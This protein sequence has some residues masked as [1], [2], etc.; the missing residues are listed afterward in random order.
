MINETETTEYLELLNDST[1]KDIE[2]LSIDSIKRDNPTIKELQF[3]IDL[4]IKRN[5]HIVANEARAY[6]EANFN[7][8]KIYGACNLDV[9]Y[10]HIDLLDVDVVAG[11]AAPILNNLGTYYKTKNGHKIKFNLSIQVGRDWDKVVLDLTVK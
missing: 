5:D 7:I 6:V 2:G 11:D 8:I 3:K 1:F 10:R 4:Y 9:L